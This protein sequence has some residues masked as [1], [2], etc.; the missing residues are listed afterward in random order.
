MHQR[1]AGQLRGP[2]CCLRAH[3]PLS[4]ALLK[5]ALSYR[6]QGFQL[7]DD[8]R[9]FGTLSLCLGYF[10]VSS[11][12]S[13]WWGAIKVEGVCQ[14]VFLGARFLRR[15]SSTRGQM[16]WLSTYWVGG[17][18]AAV[19][20]KSCKVGSPLGYRTTTGKLFLPCES[21]TAVLLLTTAASAPWCPSHAGRRYAPHK[22]FPKTV[23]FGGC[24][25]LVM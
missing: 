7:F 5:G 24:S 25:P 18:R 12:S 9:G 3:S 10:C 11:V 20:K 4:P 22:V 15:E 1:V 6:G 13:V 16:G 2:S 23:K 14:L 8:K 21:G 17:S 19:F